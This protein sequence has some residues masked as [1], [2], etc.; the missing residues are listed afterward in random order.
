VAWRITTDDGRTA[1][2]CGDDAEALDAMVRELFG[3]PER[4]TVVEVGEDDV[5]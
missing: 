4:V 5:P 2:F 3:G 1:W